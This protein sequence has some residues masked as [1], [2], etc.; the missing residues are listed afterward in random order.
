MYV[1]QR[2]AAQYAQRHELRAVARGRAARE[3]EV[4]LQLWQN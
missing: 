4:P 2:L 3:G 1:T